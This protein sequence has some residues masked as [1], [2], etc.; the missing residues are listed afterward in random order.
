MV[1]RTDVCD[2]YLETATTQV[3][4]DNI[5]DL[6][7]ICTAT[8]HPAKSHP[9]KPAKY[10]SQSTA[11]RRQACSRRKQ[12]RLLI[13]SYH[14]LQLECRCLHWMPLPGRWAEPA[15]AEQVRRVHGRVVEVSTHRTHES[16]LPCRCSGRHRLVHARRTVRHRSCGCRGRPILAGQGCYPSLDR[17]FLGA[18]RGLAGGSD[19]HV[20]HPRPAAD[21]LDIW[22]PGDAAYDSD[23]DLPAK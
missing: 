13:N 11:R 1:R 8:N 21:I 16:A 20:G 17:V 9:R 10:R 7:Q 23:G 2:N 5:P 4:N 19:L 12:I 15:T 18:W 14:Y 3:R 22:R 6:K